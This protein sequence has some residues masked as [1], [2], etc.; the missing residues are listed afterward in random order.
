MTLPSPITSGFA[1]VE[2]GQLYY[3]VT[4]EGHPLVLIHAGVADCTMWD[5]QFVALS[6]RFRVIRYDC[7]GFGR[8]KTEAAS[9]SNRQDLVDLLRYLGVER[10]H[11][12]G[13]SRAG[14]IAI[15]FTLEYP[16]MVSALIPV[17]G[18]ISGYEP[19]EADA[20]LDA[21]FEQMEAAWKAKDW[22]H[23][24][25]LEVR[26]WADGPGQPEG[27]APAAVREKVRAMC[28][29][30][31]TGQNVEPTPRPLEPPAIGRLGEIKT[32]TLVIAGGLDTPDSLVMADRMVQGIA[33]ARKVVFPSA[34]HMIPME[35]PEAFNRV[36]M[37]F[38]TATR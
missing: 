5:D 7:R 22:D 29:S 4:G 35:E 14:Q 1:P 21:V 6:G 32:P 31:Y 38:L 19:T 33:D 18:G 28:M 34:A 3:E 37:E 27:H 25:D 20:A 11:V 30:N 36:V 24:V 13:I 10:T 16:E 23:L 12:I 17:A 8:T 26:L 15:D 9:F 2:H